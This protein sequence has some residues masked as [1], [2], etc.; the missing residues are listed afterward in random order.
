MKRKANCCVSI[1]ISIVFGISLFLIDVPVIAQN[2]DE[3]Y[4]ANKTVTYEECTRFYKSLDEQYE[5]AELL[6]YGLTDIGKPLHLFVISR[7]KIF[8]AA[9][10]HAENKRV[11][12]ILNGIHPGEPDGI[13]ACLKL[14]KDILSGKMD[15]SLLQNLVVCIIPVYNIDGM[16]NRSCCS[17]ANQNGPEEY[18]FRGNARNLDLNRDFI[19]CDSENAKT[20]TKIFQEWDPDV[21]V[22]THVSDG[23]DYPYIMTLISTQ[24]NKL[25]PLPGTYLKENF[26]PALFEKMKSK[27]DEMTVY[28][29]TQRYDDSP[30]SGIYGF[31]E[32]PRFSTGYAALF[33]TIGFVAET[34]MLKPFPKR[35]Q[36]TYNLLLS[37]IEIVN[38]DSEKIG[39]MRKQARKDCAEKKQFGLQWAV[40]TTKFDMISFNGYEMK[41]KKS[42]VTGFDRTYYDRNAPYTKQIKFYDEYYETVSV[43]SP[44]YYIIPQAWKEVIYRLE[45]NGIKMLKLKKDTLLDAEMYYIENYQTSREPYEGHYLKSKVEVRKVNQQIQF[46]KGDIIIPVNQEKNRYIVETLEP[47]GV[48]SWFAWGFFDSILQQKEWFSSYVYEDKAAEILNS[49]WQLKKDF[50]IKQKSDSAFA[51]DSFSQLYYIF[52]N[53]PDFEKTFKRYPVARINYELK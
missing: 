13:D 8:D 17:R 38:R 15:E 25:H 21:M 23:A 51:A 37:V 43:T 29:N 53:S 12:L 40:D 20:F 14:S 7:D 49:N 47:Q 34:H 10:I 35:V 41:H 22:D 2:P 18:G 32:T 36:S 45:I 39:S 30:E 6:E 11:L 44:E 28:V 16:L 48:D 46:F 3:K 4:L 19:K 33:N 52:K 24:H 9:K 27:N 26:T 5:T 42:A 1:F 31:L 50:E